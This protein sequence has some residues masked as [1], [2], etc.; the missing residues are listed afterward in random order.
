MKAQL[1]YPNS[2]NSLK[3][4]KAAAAAKIECVGLDLIKNDAQALL[5]LGLL[6]A[7]A[8]CSE[9]FI[10]FEPCTVRSSQRPSDAV[11][12]TKHTG[13]VVFECKGF[14]PGTIER[15]RAGSIFRQ[16]NGYTKAENPLDQVRS[17]MFDIKNAIERRAEHALPLLCYFV[18]FPNYPAADWEAQG[19]ADSFPSQ[20]LLL[21]EDINPKALLERVLEKV[22]AASKSAHRGAGATFAEIA[23]A[24]RAFGDSSILQTRAKYLAKPDHTLGS[25]IA[26]NM[27]SD[28]ELSTEQRQLSE[29]EIGTTP[30]VV[31]GVAGSGKTTVLSIQAARFLAGGVQEEL[32]APNSRRVAAVCYNQSFA[33]LLRKQISDAYEVRTHEKLP[34]DIIVRHLNG[35]MFE[36][37]KQERSFKYI[38]V[39]EGDPEQRALG[40]IEQLRQ[41][42]E[43]NP[44][45]LDALQFDAIFVDEGQDICPEEF[46]LLHLLVRPEKMNGERPLIIF[47][48]DAQNIY[49]RQRPVWKELGIDVG[50]G[51]RSRVMKECFRNTREIVTF[52][53]N[54]LLGSQATVPASVA[55]KEFSGLS[56]LRQGNLVSEMN[57]MFIAEFA[58]KRAKS[59]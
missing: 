20:D 46:R 31:R 44:A 45:A 47:Y 7:F 8:S 4:R 15:V 36:L 21:M 49:A 54:I 9:G 58:E 26:D 2:T 53:F 3:L 50:R 19:F 12:C 52:A 17:A 51:N 37:S 39:R 35:L 34:D 48:D 30:R 24:R 32:Y 25:I 29:L 1:Q 18:A 40:Y 22:R 42:G 56:E 5:G 6:T 33:S 41:L 57:G 27:M 23:A 14:I 59:Q 55:T 11:L 13:V 38:N 28:K 43:W 10:Y 16:V